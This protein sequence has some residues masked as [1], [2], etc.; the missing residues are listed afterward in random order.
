MPEHAPARLPAALVALVAATLAAGCSGPASHSAAANRPAASATASPSATPSPTRAPAAIATPP[1]VADTADPNASEAPF[2]GPAA[3]KF[4]ATNVATAYH[5][6]LRENQQG[7]LNETLLGLSK[8]RVLDFSYLDHFFTPG[9]LAQLHRDEQKV[10]DGT[11]KT[12]AVGD[13]LGAASWGL[14]DGM[15]GLTL[16]HPTTRNFVY[17]GATTYVAKNSAGQPLLAMTLTFSTQYLAA[18]KGKPVYFQIK[19]HETVGLVQT[20]DKAQPWQI[21]SYQASNDVKGP[22][23]DNG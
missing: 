7:Y 9:V 1:P 19:H 15:P 3:D 21:D 11:A 8:P 16:R 2:T 22:R 17:G 6:V 23:P 5:L 12:D 14:T 18:L 13:V 4:G 20:G 10:H